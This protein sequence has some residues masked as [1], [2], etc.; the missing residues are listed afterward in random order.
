[1]ASMQH[2]KKLVRAVFAYRS[3]FEYLKDSKKIL[4]HHCNWRRPT[5]TQNDKEID[6]FTLCWNWAGETIVLSRWLCLESLP[7]KEECFI[8]TDLPLELPAVLRGW[9]VRN[10][11][12][13]SQCPS[14]PSTTGS[15]LLLSDTAGASYTFSITSTQTKNFSKTL[16]EQILLSHSLYLLN[17]PYRLHHN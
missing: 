3:F 9:T 14:L 17:L 10:G 7:C 15:A 8:L 16:S 2:L 4:L 6:S 11:A 5:H 13:T 12:W 1:M